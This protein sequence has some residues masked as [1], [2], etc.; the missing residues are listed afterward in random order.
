MTFYIEEID[1]TLRLHHIIVRVRVRSA[2]CCALSVNQRI[3]R[4]NSLQ[5]GNGLLP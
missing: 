2:V 1:N 4:T 3:Q 5:S